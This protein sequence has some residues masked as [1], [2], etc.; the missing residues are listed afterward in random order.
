MDIQDVPGYVPGLWIYKR[1]SKM[2]ANKSQAE[3]LPNL[4]TGYY[5]QLL[6]GKNLD[7]I[8]CYAQ[9]KYTYVKEGMPIWPEYDDTT[10]ASDLEVEPGIPVQVGIDFGLTPAAVFAQRMKNG[11]WHIIH[12]LVTFDMGLNR[13][14]TMLKEEMGI[15]F[16]GCQFMVWETLQANKE[17]RYMK[18]HTAFDHMRAMD[19]VR[20]TATNDFKVRR[21]AM[22]IP[23]Q[24]LIHGKPGFLVNKKCER[25]RKS[26]S[27]GYH[28]KEYLWA[29]VKKD[30]VAHQIKTNTRILEMQ[31]DIVC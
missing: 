17:T 27:G 3:N 22:A 21:E 8:K 25:L 6:G 16:L 26:L 13:F 31:L 5:E 14:V 2:V 7:W 30:I 18:L 4:P 20:P 12:E 23:M 19:I 29:L 15:Y 10:M 11:T 9:G 1:L 28:F 24:R